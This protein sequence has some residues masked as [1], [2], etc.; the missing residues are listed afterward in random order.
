MKVIAKSIALLCLLHSALFAQHDA[1]DYVP[2]KDPEVLK[3]LEQWQ[4][5][6]FGLF[7]HWGTYS[8]WG[9]VESWSLCNED[10]GWTERKRGRY[11]NYFEYKQDYENLQKEF[12]PVDFN[13]EK[14]VDAA[15]DAGMKYVVFTTKHHDGF[16][17]FDTKTTD[18]KITSEKSPFHSNS[19]ANVTKEIFDSF[20][21][22]EFM[23]GAYY[24]KPDWNTEYYW[25]PYFV[26]PDRHVNYDPAKYPE[27]W[28]KFKDF[29]STQIQELMTGYGSVDILWLDGAWVRPYNNIPK[30]YEEWAKK[31]TYDQDI[32]I[33]GIASMARKHQPGLIVVD[34]WVHGPYENYLTPEQ[35]VPEEAMTVPWESCITMGNSWSYVPK[36]QYKSVSKLV[37]MLVDIVAKGGNFLLNVGPSPQGDWDP[38]VYERLKGMGEW[39]KVNSEAIYESRPVKP[40]KE[41]KVALTQNK[42]TKAVY[43][44]Y[45]ADENE[46]QAPSKIWLSTIQP[47]KG[48]KVSMLGVKGNLKWKKVGNGFEVYLPASVQ[49]NP[50]CQHA[51]TIKISEVNP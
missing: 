26:N 39:M 16:C 4:D 18:Y 11:E 3:K 14:W 38:Q 49:K 35:K 41:A 8:Q 9:I 46:K 21:K 28:Q 33:P 37:H 50:P 6:K 23:I 36:D 13:P 15:K 45:L 32:D 48:A 43:A 25:W 2:V 24:S 17:M 10:V 1:E 34:R 31:K 44:I 19:K 12:N 51:W 5:Y 20:R 22:E 29:T 47:A 40:Y 7:M 27:R 30:K 42:N